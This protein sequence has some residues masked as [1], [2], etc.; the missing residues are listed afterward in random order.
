[1]TKNRLNCPLKWAYN[2]FRQKGRAI[3]VRAFFDDMHDTFDPLAI[4]N[5]T[6]R[7][8]NVLYY[9]YTN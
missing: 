3:K 8:M 1:M 6:E 2:W 5:R 7:P 4:L 9:V